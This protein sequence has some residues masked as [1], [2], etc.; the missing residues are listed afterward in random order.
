MLDGESNPLAGAVVTVQSPNLQGTRSAT[1]DRNGRFLIQGLPPGDYAVR[2]EFPAFLRSSRPGFPSRPTA[3][4]SSS[5]GCCRASA[6]RSRSPARRR[7]WMR[8]A[9]PPRRSLERAVFK[10][11]PTSRTFLDLSYLAPGVVNDARN[12]PLDQ[13]SFGESRTATSWTVW[14]SRI[15]ATGPLGSTLPVDFLQEVDIKTGGFG[16]EYGGA[17]GGILNVVTRSGSNQLHG[18]VFG[19]YKDRWSDVGS[20]RERSQRA[21]ARDIRLRRRGHAR[22]QHS[23]GPA[24]VLPGH[25]SDVRAR[26][27]DHDAGPRT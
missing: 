4:G 2:A 24:L 8:P 14:T 11:L 10:E 7:S 26:G 3:A 27:L 23:A 9:P 18:S 13:R 5:F 17:L 16:P 15:R 1:T 22:R 12:R 20:P 21:A 19:F 6:K 25:R